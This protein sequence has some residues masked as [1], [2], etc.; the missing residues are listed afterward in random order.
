MSKGVVRRQSLEHEIRTNLS[1]EQHA[2]V[3]KGDVVYNMMR[4]WQGASGVSP[5]DGV[6]SPA[7]VICEPTAELDSEY[8][9]HLFRS[10]RMIYLFWVYSHG[11]TDDRRRLYYDDFARVPV[12][13]PPIDHQRAIAKLLSTWDTALQNTLALIE[14]KKLLKLGLMQQVLTGQRRLKGFSG[15]WRTVAIG[16]VVKETRRVVKVEADVA[17]RLVSVRRNSGGLFDR[18]PRLGREIGY[19]KLMI[20]EAGDFLI[21]RRQ[22]VH[23]AMSL[24]RK[25]YHGSFVSNAYATLVAKQEDLLYL[26]FFDLL[27]RTKE[28]YHKALRSSYGVTIEKL[29]FNLDWFLRERI[30]IPEDVTEQK[31]IVQLFRHV[32]LEIR[33][34][35]KRAE[36]LRKQKTGLMQKLL[37]GEIRVSDRLIKLGA[38]S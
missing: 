2:L 4:M 5:E 34:L 28:M 22:V 37:T 30:V 33:E 1:H 26:P 23:G 19:S 16:D 9:Q 6:V 14:S 35:G 10:A 3:R 7:Y 15:K 38:K 17:Y 24:V 31:R 18:P 20:A 21:A 13:L 36:Q 11:I 8:S 29:V 27:S 32:D 12:L 25:R